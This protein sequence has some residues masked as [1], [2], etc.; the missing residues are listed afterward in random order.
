M[1]PVPT[2]NPAVVLPAGAG[3]LAIT[4]INALALG[5]VASLMI[6]VGALLLRIAY[7]A[8]DRPA[9]RVGV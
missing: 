6:V 4:G 7:L 8:T 5:V 1:Y 9:H 2:P 3:T